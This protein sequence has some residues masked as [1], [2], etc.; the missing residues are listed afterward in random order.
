MKKSECEAL[1]NSKNHLI[2]TVV[3]IIR[4]RKTK[5]KI[6][7][8]VVKIYCVCFTEVDGTTKKENCKAIA[9][10]NQNGKA[11]KV[12]VNELP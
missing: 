2:G 12:S 5:T 11:I 6:K 8:V 9:I 10:I 1:I 3:E 7:G 4:G